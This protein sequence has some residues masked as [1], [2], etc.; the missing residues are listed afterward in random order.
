MIGS[1][2]GRARRRAWWLVGLAAATGAL[3]VFGPL[4][5][6]AGPN[7]PGLQNA[8]QHLAVLVDLIE[9]LD[10]ATELAD[11]LTISDLDPASSLSGIVDDAGGAVDALRAELAGLPG[12][13]HADPDALENY[14]DGL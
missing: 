8:R 6:Q 5:A 1:T 4:R 11:A 7:D 10:E 13:E 2:R 14:L 9:R 12:D 3:T